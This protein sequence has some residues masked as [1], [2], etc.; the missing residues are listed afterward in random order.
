M[1]CAGDT[2]VVRDRGRLNVFD[3]A[4]AFVR[5]ETVV[6]R[7]APGGAFDLEGITPDCGSILLAMRHVRPPNAGERVF[8]SPT[9]LYW[10]PFDGR[11]FVPVDSFPGNEVM[12]VDLEGTLLGARFPFAV[13]PVWA[14][15]GIRTF[16]GPADRHEVRVFDAAG[17]LERVVRWNAPLE[18][19]S[20]EDWT[21]YEEWRLAVLEEDPAGSLAPARADH[22]SPD[23]RP[24]YSNLLVDDEGNAWVQ[25]YVSSILAS[26]VATAAQRWLVLD[27]QGAW[28]GTIPMPPRF[29]LMAVQRGY[30]IGVAK[31]ELDVP[32]VQVIRIRKPS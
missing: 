4:G 29:T 23:L 28:L 32:T 19:I 12:T 8:R 7:L 20:E 15:D 10:A 9:E 21:Q 30:V 17:T 24:A 1:P 31:D 13:E 16:Y 27:R 6:G 5:T 14:T 11:P 18:P 2:L 3:P 22:P 25:E 26:D